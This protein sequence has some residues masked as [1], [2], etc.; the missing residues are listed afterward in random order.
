MEREHKRVKEP[1]YEPTQD[2]END[3]SEKIHSC[4]WWATVI[5]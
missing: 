5:R 4:I 3:T 2:V 1:G